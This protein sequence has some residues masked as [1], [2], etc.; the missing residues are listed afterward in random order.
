MAINNN[1][2]LSKPYQAWFAKFSEIDTL[3]VSQWKSVHLVAYMARKYNN[4]YGIEYTFRM[5]STAPGKCYEMYQIGKLTQMIA[6]DP[7]VLKAYID[8]VWAKKVIERKKRITS[9]ALFVD[10][11]VCNEYKWSAMD[12]QI[13]R[14][15]RLPDNILAICQA[16]DPTIKTYGDLAFIECEEMNAS[17]N[18]TME[19]YSMLFQDLKTAN[20]DRSILGKIK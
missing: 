17:Y 10:A 16:L 19:K 20:F 12:N 18:N 3:D 6:K 1:E 15:T 14:T 7:I 8:W 2:E 11:N 5:N 9:F 13:D 4:H